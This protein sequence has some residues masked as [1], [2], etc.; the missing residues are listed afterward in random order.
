MTGCKGIAAQKSSHFPIQN[1][2]LSNFTGVYF[3]R[4]FVEFPLQL[5]L[6][7]YPEALVVLLQLVKLDC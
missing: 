7:R 6:D 3:S 2:L 4:S 1:V 5:W